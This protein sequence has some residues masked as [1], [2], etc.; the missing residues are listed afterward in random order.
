MVC[1]QECCQVPVF[2][3]KHSGSN[4]TGVRLQ[5]EIGRHNTEASPLMPSDTKPSELGAQ[6]TF[7]VQVDRQVAKE[8]S[9]SSYTIISPH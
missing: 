1:F 3:P 2:A 4:R 6:S 9:S 8:P 7:S 5:S